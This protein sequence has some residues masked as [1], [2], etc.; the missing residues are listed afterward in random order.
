[1]SNN[2]L[3]PVVSVPATNFTEALATNAKSAMNL[4]YGIVP[5]ASR[6]YLIQQIEVTT[7]E[8]IG[9]QFNFFASAAGFTTDPATDTFLGQVTFLAAQGAQIGASGLWRYFVNGLQMPYYDAD[10]LNSLN[11]PSLHVI[12]QNVGATS[13]SAG[14]AGSIAV[15][16]WMQAMMAG[17]Y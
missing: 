16:I 13:K 14:A 10:T 6:Q 5:Q 11:P 4:L 8:N 9:P 2:F 15:T 12:L 17:A 7:K 3:F 1:M